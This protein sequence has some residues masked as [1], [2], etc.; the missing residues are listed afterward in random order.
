MNINRSLFIFFTFFSFFGYAQTKPV[1]YEAMPVDGLALDTGWRFFAAD[2]MAFASPSYDDSA[3]QPMNPKTAVNHLPQ[4][5]N[6]AVGWLR[7]HLKVGKAVSNKTLLMDAW[8]NCASEIYLDGKLI[9]K[10][11]TVSADP[12]KMIPLGMNMPYWTVHLT[13][14]SDHVLAVRL[15][16]WHGAVWTRLESELLLLNLIDVNGYQSQNQVITVDTSIYAIDAA[17][18]FL[19]SLLHLSLFRY[20][21]AQRGNLFLGIYASISALSFMMVCLQAYF[22]D[23]RW[24]ALVDTPTFIINLMGGIWITNALGSLFHYQ[25]RRWLVLMWAVYGGFSLYILLVSLNLSLF[26]ACIAFFTLLEFGIAVKALLDKK[27]GAGI[28]AAGLGV[29]ILAGIIL[30]VAYFF[31]GS[32]SDDSGRFWRDIV[33]MTATVAPAIAISVF[34]GREFALDAGLLREKLVQ[35]ENLSA[36]SLA[37]E[38]E[39]QQI[40]AGQKQELE[41]QVKERTVELQESLD[42]LK[43]AQAQLIQSEKMASLGELTAGIAHEIQ[44]PLNFVN[45]FSEVSVELLTELKEEAKAGRPDDVLEIAEDLTQNLEKIHHHGKRADGIVKGMLEHSRAGSGAKELTDLNKLAREFLQL[46]YHGL[47]AKD[48]HF[49][50]TLVTHFA[51]QVPKINIVS[52]DIGRVL[53]NLLNNAFYAV[54]ERQKTAAADY[55]PTVEVSTSSF[56]GQIQ[57]MVKDNG[58][59]I[60]D[61]IREKIMQPFFTTKPTGQGTGLGLSLSYDIIVKGHGGSIDVKS[62]PGEG[63]AFTIVLPLSYFYVS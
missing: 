55:Q 22:Q 6:V 32:F 30:T 49:N 51:D 19:L 56:N 28:I 40:L 38:Q 48:K 58:V 34:L 60:P 43:A 35:V 47:R 2:N 21:R 37:Y 4:L 41:K 12:A 26:F 16:V 63:A 52:Q 20:D 46:A 53:L 54:R 36:Q 11:G 39:K 17:V 27:R 50:T 8:G 3:W 57:L 31:H 59:G 45:N 25:V 42:S 24:Y 7:L 13:P 29:S 18:F 33:D 44:N 1:I 10:Q 9:R 61:A 23:A 15:A 5:K 14:D 62:V